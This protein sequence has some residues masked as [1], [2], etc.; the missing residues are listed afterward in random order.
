MQESVNMQPVTHPLLAENDPPRRQ[1]I[2]PEISDDITIPLNK[3]LANEDIRQHKEDI[4]WPYHR[5][6]SKVLAEINGKGQTPI[7]ISI[8]S[9]T[10]TLNGKKRPWHIGVL[11][12]KE[13]RLQD[14]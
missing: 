5:V 3:G 10:P 4:C 11:W 14:H 2:N 12:D 13:Q 7:I 1:L 6:T 9:F 8:H